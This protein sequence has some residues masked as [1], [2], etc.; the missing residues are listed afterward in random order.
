MAEKIIF[1]EFNEDN[2]MQFGKY[3]PDV[4]ISDDVLLFTIKDIDYISRVIISRFK[5]IIEAIA[6]SE[7]EPDDIESKLDTNITLEYEGLTKEFAVNVAHRLFE[8]NEQIT[9]EDLL[10]WGFRIL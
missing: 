4:K 2:E 9:G 8:E 3:E 6:E 1:R 5:V 7:F 10:A